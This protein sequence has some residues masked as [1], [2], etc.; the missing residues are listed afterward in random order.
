MTTCDLCGT[1]LDAM[2]LTKKEGQKII[3][4]RCLNGRTLTL[5]GY[6]ISLRMRCEKRQSQ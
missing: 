5:S 4:K 2:I 3:E 6:R 1:P